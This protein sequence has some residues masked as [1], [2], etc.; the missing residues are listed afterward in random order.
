MYAT[1]FRELERVPTAGMCAYEC[2]KMET[3]KGLSWRRTPPHCYHYLS[4]LKQGFSPKKTVDKLETDWYT[5]L[6]IRSDLQFVPKNSSQCTLETTTLPQT[7][8]PKETTTLPQTSTPKETTTLQETTTPQETP[9]CPNPQRESLNAR[10]SYYFAYGCR[11]SWADASE[12]CKKYYGNIGL[13]APPD[14]GMYDTLK[15]RVNSAK[16]TSIGLGRLW[17]G[18][19]SH[20]VNGNCMVYVQNVTVWKSPY[21]LWGSNQPKNSECKDPGMCIALDPNNDA[22]WYHVSCTEKLG[23]ICQDY[24]G[25]Y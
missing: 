15:I 22:L 20:M 13:A 12:D 11:S 16:M 14:G 23:F 19:K 9:S 21:A 17:I 18:L 1:Y 25:K 3:C 8:T 6:Y 10:S 24:Q 7:S 4:T 2:L 5:D